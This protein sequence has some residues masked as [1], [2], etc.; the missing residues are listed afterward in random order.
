MVV[1]GA[2]L[3]GEEGAAQIVVEAE[4]FPLP[5]EVPGAGAGEE[6]GLGAHDAGGFGVKGA[7]AGRGGEA[8]HAGVVEAAKV[9]A[10]LAE[11][12]L[13]GEVVPEVAVEEE[14]VIEDEEVIRPRGEGL[15]EEA[16]EGGDGA[17]PRGLEAGAIVKDGGRGAPV[18]GG[19][20]AQGLAAEGGAGGAGE[21]VGAD[22]G[23]GMRGGL[24]RQALLDAV[25]LLGNEPSVGIEAQLQHPVEGIVGPRPVWEQLRRVCPQLQEQLR[26]GAVMPADEDGFA[27][28]FGAQFVRQA[29]DIIGLETPI[30]LQ[31]ER[32]GQRLQGE[33]RALA[34]FGVRRSE[35]VVELQRLPIE[36]QRLEIIDIALRALFTLRIQSWPGLRLFRVADDQD[37]RTLASGSGVFGDC[38]STEAARSPPAIASRTVFQ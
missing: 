33:A 24:L 19:E 5:Q 37:R 23:G 10:A 29:P 35:E 8:L 22:G 11:G 32:F 12:G 13:G 15:A 6:Q 25:A 31:P 16:G 17:L 38:A 28:L 34:A 18:G 21:E 27:V 36:L 30:N 4:G 26:H 14:V 7:V 2:E 20:G 9:E 1:Q 3:G